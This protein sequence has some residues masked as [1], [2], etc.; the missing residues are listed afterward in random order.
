M[1]ALVFILLLACL[2]GCASRD[3][4]CDGRL[5]RINTA[6]SQNGSQAP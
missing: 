2:V 4:R 6:P 3:V 1:R 5:T